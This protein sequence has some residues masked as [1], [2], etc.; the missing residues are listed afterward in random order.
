MAFLLYFKTDAVG[1]TARFCSDV[2][3]V[4]M[5][6]VMPMPQDSSPVL[7]ESPRN[8]NT[9]RVLGCVPREG[10]SLVAFHRVQYHPPRTTA[11]TPARTTAYTAVG[12]ANL[13]S[14]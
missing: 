6:S 14:C 4:M 5:A 13:G 2:R 9:A 10:R 1:R 7:S 3:R 8:G 12:R 11:N